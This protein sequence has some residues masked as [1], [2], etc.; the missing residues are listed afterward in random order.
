MST[1][2]DGRRLELDVAFTLQPQNLLVTRHI[3]VV[4]GSPTFE[5]WTS[6]QAMGDS[7]SLSNLNA[8]QSVVSPGSIHWLTGHQPASGDDT[9]D[10]AFARQQQTLDVGQTVDVRIDRPLVG[11]DG[12][13]AGG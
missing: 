10:T 6:F 5:V 8:F 9:L 13:V 7:V 3:A 4:S 2:D 1:N 12:A 11:A